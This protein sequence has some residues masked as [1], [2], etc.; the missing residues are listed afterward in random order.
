ML[1]EESV[2]RKIG[3]K[4]FVSQ[5]GPNKLELLSSFCFGQFTG[6][7]IFAKPSEQG[8]GNFCRTHKVL[9]L[10]YQ[11]QNLS[12][13]QM[14]KYHLSKVCL[15]FGELQVLCLFLSPSPQL[16]EQDVQGCHE[17]QNGQKC[18]D[19]RIITGIFRGE[20]TTYIHINYTLLD[21]NSQQQQR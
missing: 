9:S 15:K 12:K 2:P 5:Q 21:L 8:E 13:E 11:I 3:N 19:T 6:L 17:L 10:K 1:G 20:P 16:A 7:L 14:R 18:C 4:R